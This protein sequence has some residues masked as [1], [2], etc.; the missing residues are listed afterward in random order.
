MH[1]PAALPGLSI[2]RADFLISA[3]APGVGLRITFAIAFLDL[4]GNLRWLAGILGPMA[5]CVMSCNGSLR[6]RQHAGGHGRFCSSTMILSVP[7]ARL[8]ADLL[9][10]LF[11]RILLKPAGSD[12]DQQLRVGSSTISPDAIQKRDRFTA[13]VDDAVVVV[14]QSHV[15]HRADHNLAVADD[16]SFLNGVHPQNARLLADCSIGVESS[17][18]LVWNACSLLIVNVPPCSSST[19]S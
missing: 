9:Q 15:H 1:A 10:R 13:A 2:D 7:P 18:R 4:A 11:Q 8:T 5:A 14:G 12:L 19:L 16:R 17:G 3:V 6:Y